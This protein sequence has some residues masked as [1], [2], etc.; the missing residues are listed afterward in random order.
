LELPP[1]DRSGATPGPLLVGQVGGIHSP[2][3]LVCAQ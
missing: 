3:H 2:N 1:R